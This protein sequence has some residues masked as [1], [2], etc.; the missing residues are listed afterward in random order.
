[1]C[2]SVF[3]V[4]IEC[5]IFSLACYIF[6]LCLYVFLFFFFFFFSSRRRH[7]RSKRDWS[8]DVCSSDLTLQISFFVISHKICIFYW[9]FCSF[10]NCR[11]YI[12]F[13]FIFRS[14]HLNFYI[15]IIF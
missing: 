5:T 10:I 12:R 2:F 14:N 8:S 3:L 4:Y 1:L 6:F 9:I 11:L 13:I 15:W 7:T